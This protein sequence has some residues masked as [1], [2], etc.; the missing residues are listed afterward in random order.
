MI[1]LEWGRFGVK[2]TLQGSVGRGFHNVFPREILR[3]LCKT[4][5]TMDG[6]LSRNSTARS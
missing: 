2:S 4:F 3:D 5:P 1:P 6:E